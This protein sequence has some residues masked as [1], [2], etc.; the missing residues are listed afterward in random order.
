METRQRFL[1]CSP[2][3][4]DVSYIINPWMKGNVHRVSRNKAQKQWR[5]LFEIVSGL[6]TVKIIQSK[7]SLPDMAFTA[8][9]GLLVGYTVVPSRFEHKERR[10][11]ERVFEDW[12]ATNGF[13]LKRLPTDVTFEGAGDALFD[14]GS[15]RVWAG[16]GFR[17]HETA[18]D[19]LRTELKVDL[20]SLRLID[21][22]FFHLDTCFCPLNNG[23]LLYYPEAFDEASLR[24]IHEEISTR[25][26]IPVRTADAFNFACNAVNIGRTVILNRASEQLRF[27]LSENGF[28]VIEVELSEFMKAG[29]SAKC[30]VLRLDEPDYAHHR[31]PGA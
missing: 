25:F 26:R 20:L 16:W 30:L 28:E 21:E 24:L 13:S 2:D 27:R 8:N 31:Q 1:M 23:Y 14:R 5:R 22:R 4:F 6:A 17:C 15:R 3:Y 19:F 10:G 12:F 11:E 7:P 9:A 18:H 29:G